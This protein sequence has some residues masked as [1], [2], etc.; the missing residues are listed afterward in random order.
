MCEGVPRGLLY[1]TE[2]VLTGNCEESVEG[3]GW[4]ASHG[5]LMGRRFW[6]V[7]R[8]RTD[9]ATPCA[10]EVLFHV[11]ELD[12]TSVIYPEAEDEQLTVQL[13]AQA[14]SPSSS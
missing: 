6:A 13:P 5:R 1:A 7:D 12:K 11:L 9:G 4:L 10:R 2:L 8:V 14:P 3:P